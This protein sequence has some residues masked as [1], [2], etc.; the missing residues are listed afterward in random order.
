MTRAMR[1]LLVSAIVMAPGAA[2]GQGVLM[3]NRPA[4]IPRPASHVGARSRPRFLSPAGRSESVEIIRRIKN[5]RE[6]VALPQ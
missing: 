1:F 3:I 6:Q 4:S 2:R 5:S